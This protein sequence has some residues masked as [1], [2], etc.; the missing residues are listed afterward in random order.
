MEQIR[1]FEELLEQLD[2]MIANSDLQAG[3]DELQSVRDDVYDELL[4]T[5]RVY[6]V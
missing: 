6:V 2:R 1:E 4:K 3:G 5:R